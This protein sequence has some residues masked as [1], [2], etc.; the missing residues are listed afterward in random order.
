MFEDLMDIKPGDLLYRSKYPAIHTGI[1]LGNGNVFHNKP[2]VGE[3]I[4]SFHDF[5]E[6]KKVTAS[7]IPEAIRS[8]VLERLNH[9]LSKPEG[10]HLLTNNC[11]HTINRI[12]FNKKRSDQV[13]IGATFLLAGLSFF[14]LKR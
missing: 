11:E 4:S 8:A 5:S 9:A 14:A 7:K 6:G 2:G 12:L 3:H 13:L 10:Y 1:Y